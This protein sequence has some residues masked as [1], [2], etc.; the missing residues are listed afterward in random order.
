MIHKCLING[1]YYELKGTRKEL[2]NASIEVMEE[3][4][5]KST[6]QIKLNTTLTD[7]NIETIRETIEDTLGVEIKEINEI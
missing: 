2:L 3:V 6:I 5:K 7:D 4:K 1:N